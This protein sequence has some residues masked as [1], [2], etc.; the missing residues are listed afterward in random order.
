MNIKLCHIYCIIHGFDKIVLF[1]GSRAHGT[2]YKR[3]DQNK[4][5]GAVIFNFLQS[6]LTHVIPPRWAFVD[7]IL[8]IV[9]ELHDLRQ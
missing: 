2:R 6:P 4:I 3:C 8:E 5:N 1:A 7:S 9:R